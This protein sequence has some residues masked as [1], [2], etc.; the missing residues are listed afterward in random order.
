MRHKAHINFP[1]DNSYGKLVKK[2][3]K[4]TG[5]KSKMKKNGKYKMKIDLDN[6]IARKAFLNFLT[7]KYKL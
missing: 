5:V 4:S 3:M 7:N 6:E 1:K 2:L